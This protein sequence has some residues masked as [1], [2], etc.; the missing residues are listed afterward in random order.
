MERSEQ[1]NELASALVA[2]KKA[3][4][5]I[6]KESTVKVAT[7][8]GSS[9]SF[10]YADLST[11]DSAINEPLTANG[12]AVS[13]LVEEPGVLT[14]IL[15]H[16]SGQFI[17]T[18]SVLPPGNVSDKQAIGG[19]ITYLRRYA[20]TAILGIVAD[21]DDDGN[22]ANGN[23]AQKVA[24]KPAAKPVAKP[25]SKPAPST[26]EEAPT[27]LLKLTTEIKAKMI[28]AIKAGRHEQVSAR[29]KDYDISLGDRTELNTLISQA[30]QNT[31][32]SAS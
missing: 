19:V 7:K 23:S 2:F 9:Y 12:L 14:T 6:K 5:P 18:R 8:T 13:Q 26:P 32:S 22:Y 25:A 20:L 17:S 24:A 31:G 15:L 10:E 11:I 21:E 4:P 1:I 3:C 27:E 28:E 29:L 30:K 16:S